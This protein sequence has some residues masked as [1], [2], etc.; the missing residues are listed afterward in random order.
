MRDLLDIAILS[1]LF[2]VGGAKLMAVQVPEVDESPMSTEAEDTTAADAVY[3]ARVSEDNAAKAGAAAA[4]LEDANKQAAKQV[5]KATESVKQA[6]KKVDEASSRADK[7]TKE[8]E[9]AKKQADEA[10]QKAKKAAV[11]LESKK[12]ADE[13]PKRDLKHWSM[14]LHASEAESKRTGSL[15]FICYCQPDSICPGCIEYKDQILAVPEV[16]RK[17]RGDYIPVYLQTSDENDNHFSEYKIDGKQ[18][19]KT[20]AIVV[21]SPDGG[22]RAFYTGVNPKKTTAENIKNFL[23]ELEAARK[24]VTVSGKSASGKSASLNSGVGDGLSDDESRL[25]HGINQLRSDRDKEPVLVDPI[26]MKVAREQMSDPRYT[27]HYS[28]QYGDATHHVARYAD[29]ASVSDVVADSHWSD[30]RIS[31]PES[32]VRSWL[33][34]DGHL[35]CILG[36]SNVNGRWID[37]GYNRVG[38]A[39]G[40]WF[41][42]AVFGRR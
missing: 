24:A 7:A 22:Y 16:S 27:P 25:L 20:P 21:E 38:V 5:D 4:A 19:T 28:P 29:F 2:W 37:E 17:V 42:Y 1:T 23:D 3:Q 36:E 34:S 39:R 32:S 18:L 35:R 30:G 40:R 13:K 26:L 9:Q 33:T 6:E 31:S 41:D 12:S 10:E 8:A 14:D 15:L 11:E